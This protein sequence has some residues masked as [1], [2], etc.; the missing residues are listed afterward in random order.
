MKA[1]L[2][3]M[4]GVLVDVSRS[5]RLAIKRTVQ[6]FSGK[7]I[8]FPEIQQYKNRPGTNNDWDVTEQILRDRGQA[9][10]RETIIEV[11]QGYY[12]GKDFGGFIRDEKWLLGEDVLARVRE[13]HRLG[14]VTGRPKPEAEYVL[15]RF[16]VGAYFSCLVTMDDVPPDRGKPDPAGIRLAL[17]KL[18]V[19]EGWYVGDSVDDVEAAQG[20]G[21]VPIGIATNQTHG[22]LQAHRSL[23]LSHG[24]RYLLED[25]N[26]I[27]K[28]LT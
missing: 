28:A 4:D 11:F 3:D 22:D 9:A 18:G 27:E 16:R 6:Q 21:L 5:Y 23:L 12:L 2:F 15:E 1:V 13:G 7:D 24:A 26:S 19:R 10:D 8:T 17:E 14:I 25:V 20:A